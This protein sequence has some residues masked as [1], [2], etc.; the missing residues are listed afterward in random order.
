MATVAF[1]P[2]SMIG[3]SVPTLPGGG[4][5]ITPSDADV[6]N[7]AVV[8]Y[9]GGAGVVAAVPANSLTGSAVNVTVPA[10]GYVPFRCSA[11]KFTGTTAT[12]L[13]AVF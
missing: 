10:G 8:V 13:V 7:P 9:V 4:A 11:V 6:F 2:T 12:L 3:P 5:A 1:A